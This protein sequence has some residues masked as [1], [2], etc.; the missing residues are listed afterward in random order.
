MQRENAAGAPVIGVVGW[1]NNG[2]TTLVTRLVAHLVARG[3][4]VSTVK[5][6]HHSV[7]VDQPGKDSHRHR[8]A[9]AS[10]VVLATAR[11]WVLIHELR[12]EPE[13][14]LEELLAKMAPAD[15]V[16]V[17]G[18]KRFPHPKIE[19][20]RKARGTPLI[21]REDPSVLAVAS[22]EPLPDLDRPVFHLDAIAEIADFILARTGRR[23]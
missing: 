2:K 6:A 16:I 10:E 14:P 4:R 22:D 15:L 9:G 5:H 21:A 20:H 17:E 7:D 12:D 3:L 18:F 1:K 23:P 8:E 11:R 19:V 13:P